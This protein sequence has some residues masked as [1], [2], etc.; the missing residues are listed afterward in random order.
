MI[1]YHIKR[2][3]PVV[4][5]EE[6]E[7]FITQIISQ[8]VREKGYIVHAYNICRDHVHMIIECRADE[9]ANIVRLLKGKSSQKYKGHLN[10]RAD[11]KFHLWTQKYNK[12]MITT[13]IQFYNTVKYIIHNRQKHKLLRNAELESLIDGIAFTRL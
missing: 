12:W 6:A 9:I 13:D 7:I 1:T 11:E 8:I 4:L 10:I 5:D 2:G 3:S